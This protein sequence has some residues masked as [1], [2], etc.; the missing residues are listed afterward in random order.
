VPRHASVCLRVATGIATENRGLCCERQRSG[1]HPYIVIKRGQSLH[2]A[3][4]RI[5]SARSVAQQGLISVPRRLRSSPR[6]SYVLRFASLAVYV[7]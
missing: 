5:A 4:G 2:T 3:D 1:W 7:A 6:I